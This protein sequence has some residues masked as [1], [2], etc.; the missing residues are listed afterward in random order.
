MP[1]VIHV[2]KSLCKN[3][4]AMIFQPPNAAICDINHILKAG[5]CYL[6]VISLTKYFQPFLA[7]VIQ[8]TLYYSDYFRM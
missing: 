3:N 2:T 7:S 5:L 6:F 8:N 1:Q 4:T